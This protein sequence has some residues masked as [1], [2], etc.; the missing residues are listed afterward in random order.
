[1]DTSGAQDHEPLDAVLGYGGGGGDGEFLKE[2]FQAVVH[3]AKA[4]NAIPTEDDDYHFRM[5]TD[6]TYT[7]GI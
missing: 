7:R 6:T 5:N 4:A 2:L 1:M 3:G